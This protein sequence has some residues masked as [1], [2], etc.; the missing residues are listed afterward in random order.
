MLCERTLYFVK[1]SS[2]RKIQRFVRKVRGFI[3]IREARTRAAVV[4]LQRTL[5]CHKARRYL[6]DARF[7]ACWCQSA[8]RG[9]IARQYC[10]YLFLD[11]KASSI[12]LAWRRFYLTSFFRRFRKSVV[13][14]QNRHRARAA[15][16]ELCRLR[17]EAKDLAI[18]A[19]ERDK[20][21]EESRRLRE[22][23]EIVKQ[24]SPPKSKQFDSTK[25]SF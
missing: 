9:A 1:L 13:S 15:F 25:S 21:K 7:I 6:C 20:F 23:L 18:V 24:S 11:Q 19:A 3:L 14:V 10:A 12:Q 8:Y 4:V 5:R 16:R 2:V 17:L 22:E